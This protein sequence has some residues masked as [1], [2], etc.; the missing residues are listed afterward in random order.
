M[1]EEISGQN[2]LQQRVEKIF[3]KADANSDG[4]IDKSEFQQLFAKLSTE[5]D[6]GSQDS[7]FD[8]SKLFAAADTN[9]DGMISKDELTQYFKSHKHHGGHHANKLASLLANATDS[10]TA[11]SEI[12]TNGDGVISLA[13]LLAYIEK[14]MNAAQQGSVATPAAGTTG[15]VTTSTASPAGST[16]TL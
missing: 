9:N 10:D 14:Q 11:F 2:Y 15:S 3:S 13:E 8:P 4:S 16:G 12:D 7:G 1:V 5:K 6:D